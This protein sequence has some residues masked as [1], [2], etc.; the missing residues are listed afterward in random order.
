MVDHLFGRVA[1]SQA[2]TR[3][4]L[5]PHTCGPR[6][7]LNPRFISLSASTPFQSGFGRFLVCEGQY[8]EVVELLLFE[9]GSET[10]SVT[11]GSIEKE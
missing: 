7:A 5:T 11:R 10:E 2:G 1:R 3:S 6:K 8:F 9:S 4:K